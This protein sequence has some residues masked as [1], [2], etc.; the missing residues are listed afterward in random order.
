MYGMSKVTSKGQIT[1][2]VKVR[3]LLQIDEGDTII[4]DFVEDTLMI[5]KARAIESYFNTLPPLTDSWKKQ[6]DEVI[7]ADAWKNE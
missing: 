3:K 7:A 1:L 2:P 5:R 6:L 4:F